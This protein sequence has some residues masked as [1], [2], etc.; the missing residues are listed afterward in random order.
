VTRQRWNKLSRSFNSDTVLSS[1]TEDTSLLPGRT[2][3]DGQGGVLATWTVSPS[4]RPIP[5]HPY[6]ASHVVGGIPGAPYDLPFTPRSLA[7]GDYPTL[8]L[9]ENGTA[10]ASGSTT[11]TDGTNTNL[12]Q[13]SSFNL[14]TGI[15]NWNYQVQ[16]PNKLSMIEATT[17]NGLAAKTTDQSG[18]ETVQIFNSSGAQGQTQ[19]PVSG[20][21]LDYY[22]NG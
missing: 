9:G 16:S 14:S 12:S 11:T 4:N 3:P 20:V 13:I 19:S 22:S 18:N 8:V 15:P 21:N 17:G 2:I 6:Q 1:T 10:F 5:A 7:A